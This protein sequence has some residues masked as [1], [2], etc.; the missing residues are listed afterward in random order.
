MSTEAPTDTPP[1]AAEA[2]AITTNGSSKPAAATTIAEPM[3]VDDK[4]ATAASAEPS[5]D[6]DV[7]EE[8]VEEGAQEEDALFTALEH[9]EEEK[10]AQAPHDQPTDVQAAPTLLKTALEK[11][12]VKSDSEEDDAKTE[13]KKVDPAAAVEVKAGGADHHAHAR[14]RTSNK[15]FT[16]PCIFSPRTKER[17]K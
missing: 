16:K 14:V 5:V 4:P 10:E 9:S 7:I 8:D 11:G 3:Q 17:K 1:V 6:D 2:T 13:E 15:V 12:E